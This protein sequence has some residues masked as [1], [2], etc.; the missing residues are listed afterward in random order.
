MALEPIT[1]GLWRY[2]GDA[3]EPSRPTTRTVVVAPYG[4]GSAYSVHELLRHLAPTADETLVLQYPARGP[5]IGEPPTASLHDLADQLAQDID[6]HTTGNLVLLGHSLGGLLCFELAHR[7]TRSGRHVELLV[8]SSALPTAF[9][10]LRAD[11]IESRGVE[12]WVAVLR[13]EN[14]VTEEILDDPEMR[15]LA[16]QALRS[17]TLLA[18]RH[19]ESPQPLTCPMFVVAGDADPDITSEHLRGW[20]ELT[21]GP[22]TTVLLPGDHFYYRDR[23]AQLGD[24][25]RQQLPLLCGTGSA[26]M[27]PTQEEDG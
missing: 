1:R 25:I 24:L 9:R 20:E 6:Q 2:R 5:R 14:G 3:S 15:R 17:D 12:Q 4:G 22:A 10:K 18:A 19:V 21:L 27:Y 16:I 23:A 11:E 8:I 13:A 26:P 7:L